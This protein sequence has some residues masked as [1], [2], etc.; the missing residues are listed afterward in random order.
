MEVH[1]QDWEMTGHGGY[2]EDTGWAERQ[3]FMQSRHRAVDWLC[4]HMR[5]QF[6]RAIMSCT[7]KRG[8]IWNRNNFDYQL[9]QFLSQEEYSILRKVW[10]VSGFNTLCSVKG[11]LWAHMHICVRWWGLISL[12][13]LWRPCSWALERPEQ[14]GMQEF[15]TWVKGESVPSLG[16]INKQINNN[17]RERSKRGHYETKQKPHDERTR[18]SASSS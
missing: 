17:W 4:G 10:N 11:G 6:F 14:P 5:R 13:K 18:V 9:Q 16:S 7:N 1:P 12:M 15:K 2:E 3:T 8:A